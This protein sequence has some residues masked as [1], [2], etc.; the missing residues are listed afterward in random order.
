VDTMGLAIKYRPNTLD[1]VVGQ[2]EAVSVIRAFGSRIPHTVLMHGSSGNGKTSLS[3]IMARNL[4]CDPSN[5][6][7]F[8]EDNVA[9]WE[10]PLENVR[11]IGYEVTM[12]PYK[13]PC[14]VHLLD[15][16]QSLSRAGFTQQAFL[17]ILEDHPPHAYFFLCTTDT[18]KI[19]PAIQNRC[20]KIEIKDIGEA[21]LVALLKRV[22]KA[23][24]HEVAD[25]VATKIAE[26]ASGSARAALKELEKSLVLPPEERLNALEST[27]SKAAAFDLVR[28]L[29]LF[30]TKMPNWKKCQE[31]LTQLGDHN[32]EEI[33]R[34]VLKSARSALLKNDGPNAYKALKIMSES[35][36]DTVT[37][38]AFLVRDIYAICHATAKS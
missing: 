32:P 24:G 36:F 10:S 38:P 13:A 12:K 11:N 25:E 27:G 28:A 34:M 2:A 31:I 14:R 23:E 19:L 30:G 21:Q 5:T 18:S 1:D 29:D 7:D 6:M 15:E 22:A 8:R 37:G 16:V 9:L 17:K 20:T 4:G 26:L 35:Y 33:R 3:R